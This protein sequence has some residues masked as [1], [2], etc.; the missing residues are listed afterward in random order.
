MSIVK[1]K[2]DTAVYSTK[3]QIARFLIFLFMA[4]RIFFQRS[5]SLIISYRHGEKLIL[6]H[7]L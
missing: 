1:S 3:T 5:G 6:L 4:D 2:S 7:I